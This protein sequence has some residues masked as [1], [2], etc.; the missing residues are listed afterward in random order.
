MRCNNSYYEVL[1]GKVSSSFGKQNDKHISQYN[2]SEGN[3]M[4]AKFML[5]LRL[6]KGFHCYIY[7]LLLLSEL[8]CMIC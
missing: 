3:K 1:L 4:A 2:A 6:R 8:Q 7:Y 5:N